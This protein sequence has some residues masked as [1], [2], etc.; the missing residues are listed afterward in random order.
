MVDGRFGTT[1]LASLSKA[2]AIFLALPKA[3]SDK[4]DVPMVGI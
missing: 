1:Q 4:L 2:P 3:F